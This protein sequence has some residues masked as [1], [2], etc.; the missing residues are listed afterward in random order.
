MEVDQKEELK[1]TCA[2][3]QETC[4]LADYWKKP[5]VQMGYASASK[6]LYHT[7]RQTYENQKQSLKN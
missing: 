5:F 7:Y 1:L 4:D 3:C 6:L 2:A